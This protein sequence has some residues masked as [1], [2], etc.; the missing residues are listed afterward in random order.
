M[1]FSPVK[2]FGLYVDGLVPLDG[3]AFDV[4]GRHLVAHKERPELRPVNPGYLISERTSG[5]SVPIQ[6]AKTRALAAHYA[7]EQMHRVDDHQWASAIAY[8]MKQRAAF[9]KG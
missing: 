2:F 7:V 8:A 3:Y 4:A 9:K 5:F 6:P 1:K